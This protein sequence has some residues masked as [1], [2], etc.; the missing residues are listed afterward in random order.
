MSDTTVKTSSPAQIVS[1]KIKS[2]KNFIGK[3]RVAIAVAITL[4]VTGTMHVKQVNAVNEFLSEHGL[5]EAYYTPDEVDEVNIDV[6]N[7]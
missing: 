1:S 6:L 4:A 7:K 5:L 3:H 2:A